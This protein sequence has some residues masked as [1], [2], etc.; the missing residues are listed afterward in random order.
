MSEKIIATLLFAF[1]FWMFVQFW[2]YFYLVWFK[3]D[4]YLH[5]L[6]NDKSQWYTKLGF[7]S[8]FRNSPYVLP[9]A[10][11]TTLFCLALIIPMLIFV[12]WVMIATWLGWSTLYG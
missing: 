2:H 10:R 7:V 8:S 6:R 11:L 5:Q 1:I 3:S 4:E 9:S 12:S